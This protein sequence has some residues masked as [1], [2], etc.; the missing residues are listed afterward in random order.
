MNIDSNAVRKF[1]IVV[2]LIVVAFLLFSFETRSGQ[3]SKEQNEMNETIQEVNKDTDELQKEIAELQ[4][5]LDA[6]YE[7]YGNH[8]NDNRQHNF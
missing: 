8:I 7:S 1:F 4:Q 2:I 6:F 5:Q 3:I